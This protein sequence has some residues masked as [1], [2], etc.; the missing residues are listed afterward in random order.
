MP[1]ASLVLTL[2]SAH[3]PCPAPAWFDLFIGTNGPC[4][5]PAW[6]DSSI[7]PNGQR[8]ACR[9]VPVAPNKLGAW[10]CGLV[11]HHERLL[12]FCLPNRGREEL[13]LVQA[14]PDLIVLLSR[15]RPLN[16]RDPAGVRAPDHQPK[17]GRDRKST[18]LN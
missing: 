2:P 12:G 16:S 8:P 6:F 1:W 7:G 18:R 10:G 3:G 14:R 15:G 11:F 4:R 9:P 5:G 13:G 17:P